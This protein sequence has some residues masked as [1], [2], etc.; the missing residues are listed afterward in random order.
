MRFK[1][2]TQAAKELAKALSTYQDQPVVVYALPRGGV[3]LGQMIATYLHAPF[4]LLIP[5]K[6]G[7]PSMPEY[8]IAA[9]TESGDLVKNDEDMPDENAPWFKE[10]VERQ[11]KEAY[12]RRIT[13]LS[14]TTPVDTNGK[15]AIIVDDGM[16]TGLTMKAA[17]VDL[18]RLKPKSIIIAVPVVPHDTFQKMEKLV[19]KIITLKKPLI[20]LGSI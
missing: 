10:E 5:R 14:G 15:I 13:Y 7:Y 8:A 3:I 11:R 9:V 2:R 1:D 12:R 20:F 19:D 16:A 17:I 6:I 18:K 4:D